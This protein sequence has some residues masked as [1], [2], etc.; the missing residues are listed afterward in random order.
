MGGLVLQKIILDCFR[1]DGPQAFLFLRIP[2][3]L[4]GHREHIRETVRKVRVP[5][6]MFLQSA[7][8]QEFFFHHPAPRLIRITRPIAAKRFRLE[9][10]PAYDII[11]VQNKLNS[12]IFL[13]YRER[14]EPET[15][16]EER[17][18]IRLWKSIDL[19]VEFH[20]GRA[21]RPTVYRKI[22]PLRNIEPVRT[23]PQEGLCHVTSDHFSI[24]T[25][26]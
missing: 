3:V 16:A 9:L 13:C 18:D 1:R 22:K 5:V 2:P 24:K 26:P 15:H 17:N 19:T 25:L 23:D 4:H 8:S 20:R 12:R 21:L 11:F 10:F 6:L 7:V 14:H